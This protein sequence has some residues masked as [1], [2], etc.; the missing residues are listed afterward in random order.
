M[1]NN[2]LLT[3]NAFTPWGVFGELQFPTGEVFYTIERPWL[4]NEAYVS[5]IPDGVYTLEKRHSPVVHR[6]SGGAY[7]EGWEVTDVP[8]RT[9]IMLHPANWM[10]DLAGCIGVGKRYAVTQNKKAQWVPSVL[11]SRAAFKE[12]MTLM[13]ECN[14]WIMD[15]RPFI[16]APY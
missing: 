15:I 2:L 7:Q 3:R 9:F 5:C 1:S 11:D 14:D 8:G 16:M 6:T 10:D 12:V 4:N 13:D